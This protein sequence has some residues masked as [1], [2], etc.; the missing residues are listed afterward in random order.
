MSHYPAFG[1]SLSYG[2]RL[3]GLLMSS[4]LLAPALVMPTNVV[5][6]ALLLG[7]GGVF[8][9]A[10]P[11]LAVI[12]FKVSPFIGFRPL[13]PLLP[14]RF[15]LTGPNSS[16]WTFLTR[17][18]LPVPPLLVAPVNISFP[19]D[20]LRSYHRVLNAILIRLYDL[21]S[22]L[23]FLNIRAFPIG[24]P[25]LVPYS[26]PRRRCSRNPSM[27]LTVSPAILLAV[28]SF[29]ML[30]LL[31]PKTRPSGTSLTICSLYVL[32]KPVLL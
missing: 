9:F 28:G 11:F 15:F 24:S 22:P 7:G 31:L 5:P 29:P 1:F 6:T 10:W 3:P 20:P 18:A 12:S 30:F 23:P 4:Y 32:L 2:A 21:T 25:I 16:R 8:G 13:P 17:P 14:S 19:I 26:L 27:L